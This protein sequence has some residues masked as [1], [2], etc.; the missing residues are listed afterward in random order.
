MQIIS[1]NVGS[2]PLARGTVENPLIASCPPRITPACAG[3]RALPLFSRIFDRDHPRLRGEQFTHRFK[4]GIYKG[5]P[6]LARGTVWHC[7]AEPSTL[8]ITPACAGN[9]WEKHRHA[10]KVGD[11][12]RL[13]GEQLHGSV[14]LFASPGSPPLARGTGKAVNALPDD[15]GITPACAGNRSASFHTPSWSGDHPRL[16]G[17]QTKKRLVVSCIL[18]YRFSFFNQFFVDMFC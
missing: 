4:G 13:R 14:H 17:E 11:H 8:R 10:R 5:S 18:Q 16:R 12:P 6:P 3:N 7:S 2:P 9:R 1:E 15:F